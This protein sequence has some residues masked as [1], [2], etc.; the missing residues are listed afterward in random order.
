MAET[1]TKNQILSQAGDATGNELPAIRV[2]NL[3]K[4]FGNK[5]AL[6]RV[7]FDVKK[8]E[9]LTI[10]G[11]NGA[12]KTTLIRILS[13]ISTATSGEI[14]LYGL[15][16]HK[17]ATQIRRQIGVIAHQTFLYDDLTAEENLRFYGRL[18]SVQG[19]PAKIEQIITDVGLHLR[20]RDRVRTFSRGM[21]QR[22]SIARA[23]LH[24]PAL[25]LLDEPYTGLDQHA[26]EML[27]GWLRRLRSANRTTLMVTHDLERGV[28]LA[29]RIA[30][31]TNGKL[32]FDQKR[33]QITPDSFRDTYYE[34]V[35]KSG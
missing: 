35:E 32:V 9:F 29:D 7:S 30:I 17:H 27:S 28:D 34:F 6:N 4:T 19:L 20:R 5:F 24:D 3:V 1:N 21:Q 13:T 14:T 26:S 2:S 31:L 8:G 10:F 16:P 18:Y 12:G 15:S 33:S 22:L 25:L 11:P 23:M